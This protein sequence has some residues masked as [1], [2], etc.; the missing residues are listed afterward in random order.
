MF[1]RALK[2]EVA[3]WLRNWT[4]DLV[5]DQVARLARVMEGTNRPGV[6]VALERLKAWGADPGVAVDVGA[7]VGRWTTAFR[8]IFPGSRVLMIEAQRA[9]ILDL[10]RVVRDEGPAVAWAIALLGSTDGAP[11]RFT[12][13]ESG[14]SVHE[15]QSPYPRRYVE[16][17]TRTLDALLE[18]H[19]AFAAPRFLK[20][21]VQGY[22]LA[23]LE[24]SAHTL[25]GVE[26]VLLEASLLPT[27][28]GC[29]LFAEVVRVM[30][31]YGF[32]LLDI[33]SL[34]RRKDGA[35]WQADLLFARPGAPFLPAA[36]LDGSN[37]V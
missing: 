14:S 16:R 5:R 27:N 33:C 4:P 7:Y 35:L 22:E 37:W 29:P 26:V 20:L 13:M 11:V 3:R 28:A 1:S 2:Q 15:E 8:K 10:E 17:V 9:K 6:E 25:P 24:G 36:R 34:S 31:G 21:D 30:E 18:E 23:V 12:V 19:P 32:G